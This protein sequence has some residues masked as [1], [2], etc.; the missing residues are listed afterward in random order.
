MM[1]WFIKIV[2]KSFWVMGYFRNLRQLKR[3]R[4]DRDRDRDRDREPS[5]LYQ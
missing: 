5:F 3:E 4:E 2:N 1:E